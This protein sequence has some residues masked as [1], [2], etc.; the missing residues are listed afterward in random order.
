MRVIVFGFLLVSVLLGAG[1]KRYVVGFVQDSLKNKWR[2]AQVEQFKAALARYPD[3]TLKVLESAGSTA[4]QIANIEEMVASGVDLLVT[5]P[6]DAEAMTPILSDVY[7]SGMPV[8]LLSRGIRSRDFTAYR[9]ADDYGI[10][11]K[12]ARFI[13]KK[14]QRHGTV[15][16]LKGVPGA[17][18]ALERTR[19][20]MDVM[21]GHPGIT[22][23]ER[24]GNYL[25]G[26]AIKETEELLNKNLAFDAIYA[27]SD[28]MAMGAIMALKAHGID[29]KKLVITGIDF[30]SMGKEMILN[31]ELDA[32]FSYPTAGKE[33]ASAARDI[34][35]GKKVKKEVIIDSIM[36]TPTNVKRYH[37]I[38]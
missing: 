18:T 8:V 17:T 32:T 33:G 15:L 5:S 1:E 27:Q 24:T 16:M 28:S 21:R 25:S 14:L 10:G 7:R 36:V 26:D 29:P 4:L 38:F 22:V 20:F 6:R 31:G 35:D 2:I 37:P 11:Q 30:T 34:L 19:G 9:H 12:S 3:I 13:A 23:I